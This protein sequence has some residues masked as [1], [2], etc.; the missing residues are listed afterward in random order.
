VKKK[1]IRSVPVKKTPEKFI[2]TKKGRN[3]PVPSSEQERATDW[4]AVFCALGPPALIVT[5]DHTIIAANYA[6]CHAAGKTETELQG[7]KCWEVFHGHDATCPPDGCPMVRLLASGKH[8]TAEMEV[9][10]DDGVCLVSCTPV[11]DA[12]GAISSIIHI[13]TDITVKKKAE[14][15]VQESEE[16][17]RQIFENSPVGMALVTPDFRFF[18]V[19]PAWV[20]MTG[21]TEKE[22][23]KMS[24]KDITHLAHRAGDMEHILDLVAGKIPVYATEKQYIRKDGSILWGQLSVTAIRDPDGSLQHFAAQIEDVTGRRQAEQ[25]LL[26]QNRALA[27]INQLATEFASMSGDKSI[28]GLAVK[29]L[30]QLSGAAMVSFSLY[31]PTDRILQI[32][33]YEIVPGMLEKT[34]RLL[35]KRLGD[36]KIP[37]S[38]GMYREIVSN[39]VGTI[40][41]LTEVSS[42]EI[43]PLVGTS[44]QK[45][46]GIDH[47]IGIAYVIEGELYGTSILAMKHGQADPSTQILESFAHIVA[48]LLRRYR[49]E[50]SLAASEE[51]YRNLYRNAAIGI[52]H[53]GFDGR[54]IDVN[55]ALAK[56]LGYDSPEEVVT[57]VTSIAEQV[58]AEPPQYNT[59]STAILNAGGVLS[60]ENHY[61]RKDGSRFYGM[62][63]LRIVPDQNGR[64]GHYEGFVEDITG[65][66]QF[67]DAL[68]ELSAYN[69][70]LIEASL[71]PLVTISPEGKIQDVNAA[72]EK[73]TGY[74]R[75]TLIGTDFS[76]YFMEP[77]RAHEG[78]LRVF[79]EGSVFDYPLEIRHRDGRTVSVLYNATVYRDPDGNVQGVF[80]AARDITERRLAEEVRERA[81]HDLAQKNAEL[82]RFAYTVSHDLK[83]PIVGI[84]G[85]LS[86]LEDDLKAGD[87]RE[88]ENDI[89]RIAESTDKLEQLITTLLALSRSGRTVDVPVSIPFADLAREAA[90]M[91]EVPLQERGVR[92]VI[93]DALPD[94]SGDRQRLLRVMT[95]LL[96]NAIKFMGDQQEPCIETG[97]RTDAGTTVFFVR[98]NG[99]GFK[100]ENLQ[101]VFGLYERFNP[102]IPGTGIGLATVKRIIEAHGGKIWVESEGGGKGTRICFTLPGAGDGSTDKDNNR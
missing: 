18:A 61:R 24:F 36:M 98:D 70:S 93:P 25:E 99:M 9:A 19:N 97:V 33:H 53:S 32:T 91:L 94:I 39:P 95:N 7:M 34:V 79:S 55:P 13:A 26:Q 42:G 80:A 60:R 64:P 14:R 57:S 40:K 51:K 20:S 88:T 4:K 17:F 76:D 85:F 82:D 90:G 8:E 68:K 45:V 1:P 65:R 96:D 87:L 100:K 22:L 11:V 54:F 47:F 58:Y 48:V 3:Q 12:R 89:R 38:P 37:V 92:L 59:V 44:I 81:I 102:E 56:M 41:T 67:E 77:E 86:L 43:S 75:D 28:A 30:M 31:D 50:A 52:F 10:I 5:P 16:Q 29:K 72:T 83:S 46:T 49:A 6:T 15:Q 69:R 35:G 21:Y 63:H 66:K 23:L 71:D 2:G 27:A 101:K 74:S 84:R 73:V 78:Y 62:L